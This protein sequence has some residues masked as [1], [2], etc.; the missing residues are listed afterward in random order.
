MTILM[1]WKSSNNGFIISLQYKDLDSLK[2]LR[3]YEFLQVSKLHQ[4]QKHS[5]T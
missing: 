3:D 2:K 5:N 1:S 4:I